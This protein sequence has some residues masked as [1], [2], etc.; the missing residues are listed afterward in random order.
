[1]ALV[2]YP[3]SS[4]SE[5]DPPLP[6]QAHVAE[7]NRQRTVKRKRSHDV[8]SNLPPLPESFH[9]L[10]ASPS[11][12]ASQDDPSLHSGRQRLTPHVEGHWPTHVYIECE[13]LPSANP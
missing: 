7:T 2:D 11:R 12:T 4:S 6:L 8:N 1:M 10:Y 9:D 13:L 3:D 5:E